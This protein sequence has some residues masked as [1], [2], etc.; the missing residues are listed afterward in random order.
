MAMR[1]V[2]LKDFAEKLGEYV[3]LAEKGETFQITH[4]GRVLAELVPPQ[5][6][7]AP[8]ALQLPLTDALN[9]G[10]IQPATSDCGIPQRLPI[11]SFKE[12]MQELQQDRSDG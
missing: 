1:A 9:R 12:L 6:D 3:H 7:V 2:S 10:W 8:V 4:R 11:L 5:R